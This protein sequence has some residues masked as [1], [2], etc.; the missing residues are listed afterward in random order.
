MRSPQ[1]IMDHSKEVISSLYRCSAE[2]TFEDIVSLLNKC[3]RANESCETCGDK[4][5]CIKV[6]DRY[7]LNAVEAKPD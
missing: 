1:D 4:V 2:L 7:C 5:H 6:F 3:S